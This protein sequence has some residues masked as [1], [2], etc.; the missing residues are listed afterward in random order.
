MTNLLQYPPYVE[1]KDDLFL[2]EINML[3]EH[4]L[5][6]CQAYRR[7]CKGWKPAG[8]IED[9][10]FVHVGVFKRIELKTDDEDLVFKR[11][12]HSSSTTG[13]SSRIALDQKSSILQSESVA[14]ILGDFLGMEKRPLL[15]LDSA[16]SLRR[17]G[18][19]S[20]RVAAAMSLRP[21]ASDIVFLLQ[22]SENPESIKWDELRN[23]L[24]N[25]EKFILYGFSWILWLAWGVGHFPEDIRSLLREK[26]IFFVHSGG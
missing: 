9:V 10:P 17:R 4:H 2:S 12:V 19:M 16:K 6:G 24:S 26:E 8:R 11:S 23:V 5:A 20:A 25:N 1:R 13:A 7:I 18:E 3:S 14:K 21:M 22:D 15:V